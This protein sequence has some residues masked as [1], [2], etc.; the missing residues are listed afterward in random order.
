M[1]PLSA[2]RILSGLGEG[3]LVVDLG[4][5]ARPLPRADFVIDAMPYE[6]RGTLGKVHEGVERFTPASWIRRD[7]CA[8]EP[9]PFP[10]KHFDF[11][12]CS[13]VLEDVR[14]PVFVCSEMSRIAKRGYVETPS[15]LVEQTRGVESNAYC[16]YCHHRWYVELENSRLIFTM[17]SD[18]PM[19]SWRLHLPKRA[20]GS[21]SE[22]DRVLAF[23]WDGQLEARERL[24]ITSPE[25]EAYLE[26]FVRHVGAYSTFRYTAHDFLRRAK[27]S[28][29][30]QLGAQ[31]PR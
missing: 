30:R 24:L 14:D 17:K 3:D 6:S 7:L 4:A 10:D 8:R 25:I 1:D 18:W 31:L 15:R 5:W 19:Q 27:A 22:A 2:Q 29:K 23:F 20:L 9:Y 16:G 11:A 12:I 28:L 21:K 26:E 13:H